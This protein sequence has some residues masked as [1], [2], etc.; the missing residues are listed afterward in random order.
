ME[1]LGYINKELMALKQR[2]LSPFYL[3]PSFIFP[4]AVFVLPSGIILGWNAKG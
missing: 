3:T 1:G 4:F 2:L